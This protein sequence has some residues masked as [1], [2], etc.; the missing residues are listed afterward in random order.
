MKG[1]LEMS[2]EELTIRKEPMG[3]GYDHFI[4]PKCKH[5]NPIVFSDSMQM[6]A[7]TASKLN[8]ESCGG[9]FKVAV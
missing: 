4:C 7:D 9:T 8:C 3:N 2:S 1:E 5:D 6:L